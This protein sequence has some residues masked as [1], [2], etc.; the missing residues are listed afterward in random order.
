MCAIVVYGRDDDDM[1]P[2]TVNI[3]VAQ[4]FLMKYQQTSL[5]IP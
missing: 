2:V 3:V 1:S 4:P 5:S